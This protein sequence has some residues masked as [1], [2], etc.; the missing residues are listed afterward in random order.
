MLSYVFTLPS[1]LSAVRKI[2]LP[3]PAPLRTAF[4]RRFSTKLS[5][6]F[7]ISC[8]FLLCPTV[9][10]R[11]VQAFANF[12]VVLQQREEVGEVGEVVVA[13]RPRR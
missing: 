5:A 1:A 10:C 2:T 3:F 7:P 11:C 9:Y 13:E 8:P 6:N 12:S 4:A